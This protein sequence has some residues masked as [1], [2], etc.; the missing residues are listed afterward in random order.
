MSRPAFEYPDD[1]TV[2]L[3]VNDFGSLGR[4]FVETDIAEADRETVIRNFLNGQYSNPLRVV[5]FNTAEAW[6][7]DVSEDI[8]GELLER[9][10][11]ADDNLGEDT[12]RFIDRHVTPGEKRPPTPSLRRPCIAS[13]GTKD[14]RVRR[15]KPR[16]C[17]GF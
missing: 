13:R 9:A 5:A 3:V 2:Y 1:V 16:C 10:F 4:A 7:R 6:S 17:R 8:A 12:K 14:R 11:D 15:K